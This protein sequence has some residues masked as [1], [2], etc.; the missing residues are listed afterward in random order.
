MEAD[1]RE[2]AACLKE[3]VDNAVAVALQKMGQLR[4]RV[5]AAQAMFSQAM[6]IASEVGFPMRWGHTP[7][8]SGWLDSLH[9]IFDEAEAEERE[10]LQQH[11][12]L[13]RAMLGKT[14]HRRLAEIGALWSALHAAPHASHCHSVPLSPQALWAQ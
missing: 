11:E 2:K 4:A 6:H 8:A 5:E 10:E 14:V 9:R 3:Q 7:S 1:V 12:G 13:T